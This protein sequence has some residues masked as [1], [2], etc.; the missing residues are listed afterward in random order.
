MGRRDGDRPSWVRF[1]GIGI[2]FAAALAGFTLVGYWIDSHYD[3][4]PWGIVIG[5]GLGL[6]GGT[7]N[8]IRQSLAAFENENDHRE[9]DRSSRP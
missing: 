8:L 2:E 3:S 6:I 9:D 7:Y 4:R 1:S 5:A